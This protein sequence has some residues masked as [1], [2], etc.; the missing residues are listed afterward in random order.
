MELF[1]AID[2]L[3]NKVVRLAQGDY[4]AVTVYNDDPLAQ[5]LAFANSGARWLHVVDLEGAR[6]GV[7]TQLA[8]IS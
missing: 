8:V 6:S 1:C 5:A 3:D 4:N 7:P 2:I